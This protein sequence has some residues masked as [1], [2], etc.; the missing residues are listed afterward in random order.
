MGKIIKFRTQK[1]NAK[2]FLMDILEEVDNL[3]IDNIMIASKLKDETIITGYTK[4]LDVGRKQ[5]LL[6]HLQ[7]NIINE[8][9]QINYID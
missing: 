3:G 2:E 1:E 9:V 8:I 4:N 6:G 5:E 7:V